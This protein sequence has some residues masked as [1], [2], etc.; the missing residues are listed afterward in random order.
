VIHLRAR[1]LESVR[2]NENGEPPIGVDRDD[3]TTI[4]SVHDTTIGSDRAWQPLVAQAPAT[5]RVIA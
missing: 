5:S 4:R 3:H 2:R 1:L